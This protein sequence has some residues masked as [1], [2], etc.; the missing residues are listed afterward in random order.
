[1]ANAWPLALQQN[2]CCCQKYRLASF[3]CN[4]WRNLIPWHKMYAWP[5]FGVFRS[6]QGQVFF[7][8]V[9]SKF[10]KTLLLQ[11]RRNRHLFLRVLLPT[12]ENVPIASSFISAV[13]T[14][15]DLLWVIIFGAGDNLHL[16][17]DPAPNADEAGCSVANAYSAFNA[18]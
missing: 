4:R 10:Y 6:K 1:M 18:V 7:L 3:T 15:L 14:E 2:A 12:S 11:Q 5:E 9:I 13:P 16:L 17:Y 8:F